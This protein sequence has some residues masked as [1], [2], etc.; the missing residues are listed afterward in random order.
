MKMT[1]EIVE[2]IVQEVKTDV[3]S[4]SDFCHYN[5]MDEVLTFIQRATLIFKKHVDLTEEEEVAIRVALSIGINSTL[6][7][8]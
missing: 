8:V 1:A 4:I 6:R 5:K 2:K 7:G 3:E